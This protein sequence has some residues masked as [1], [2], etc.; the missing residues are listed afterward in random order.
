MTGEENSAIVD[1]IDVIPEERTEKSEE[2]GEHVTR[3][4]CLE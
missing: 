4:R 1:L 2:T 3:I